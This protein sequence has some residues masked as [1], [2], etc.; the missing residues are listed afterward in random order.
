MPSKTYDFVLFGL[1]VLSYILA[2]A[3]GLWFLFKEDQRSKLGFPV[4]VAVA[5]FLHTWALAHTAWAAGKLPLTNFSDLVQII[6]WCTI[7]LI[8]I[9]EAVF[10]IS[11]VTCFTVGACGIISGI[12]LAIEA[13]AQGPQ[14]ALIEWSSSINV[15]VALAVLTYGA[16]GALGVLNFIYLLQD[17]SLANKK[18]NRSLSLLPSLWELHQASSWVLRFSVIAVTLTVLA[19]TLGWIQGRY[20][21]SFEKL[22]LSWLIWCGYLAL[23][24]L[25]RSNRLTTRAFSWS[26][27]LLWFTSLCFL[28]CIAMLHRR[29]IS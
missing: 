1:A 11:F 2:F 6:T 18:H 21:L 17:Y 24:L 22:F 8:I 25:Q 26:C 7:V 19:G 20:L 10:R 29:S 12:A 9:L 3:Y 14:G 13:C 23:W 27:C 5:F 4:A 28:V 16:L 15:H